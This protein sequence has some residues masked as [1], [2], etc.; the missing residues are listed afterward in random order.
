MQG[1]EI[2]AIP[3]L[4]PTKVTLYT[5]IFYNSENSIRDVNSFCRPLFC[6][7]SCFEVNFISLTVVKPLWDLTTKYY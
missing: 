1:E 3:P 6:H 2:G 4:K 7:R 5:I